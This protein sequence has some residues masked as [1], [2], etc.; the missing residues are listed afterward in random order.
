MA[1]WLFNF[2]VSLTFLSLID[3]LGR[4]GAFFFYAGICVITFIFCKALVPETKGKHLEDI[5]AVFEGRA[6]RHAG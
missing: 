3:A 4:G 2:I 5:Q 1:N 6:A